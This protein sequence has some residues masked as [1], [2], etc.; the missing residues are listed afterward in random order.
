M[1]KELISRAGLAKLKAEY[2][3][4]EDE[5]QKTTVEMGE[6][7]KRDNDLRENPEFMELRVKAM[8]TLPAQKDEL[9]WKIF[10]A[11]IIEETPE[12]QEFDGS[13][14]IVGSKV[15]FSMGGVE[16]QFT[17]L[18][19]TEGD[20]K[21]GI[22]ACDAPIAEALLGKHVDD[23]FSFNSKTILVKKIEKI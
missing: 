15:T 3:A 16:K 5:I 12:Y 2:A 22:I 13:T 10:N 6:S 9:Y 19:S 17:I 23:A 21:Q 18:G 11:V 7:A 1:K 8:H 14:V 4:I 20:L